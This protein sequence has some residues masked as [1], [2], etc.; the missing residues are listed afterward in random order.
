[1][2]AWKGRGF[3]T[4][5]CPWEGGEPSY[6]DIVGVMDESP[7]SEPEARRVANICLLTANMTE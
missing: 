5:G 2:D 1:M 3:V 4:C 6:D 7:L